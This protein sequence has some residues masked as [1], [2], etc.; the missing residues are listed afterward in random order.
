MEIIKNILIATV[1]LFL[2]A[3]LLFFLT[4]KANDRYRGENRQAF[5]PIGK[6]NGKTAMIIYQPAISARI[7]D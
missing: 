7:V 3:M 4:V 2:S 6:G 5:A 1:V